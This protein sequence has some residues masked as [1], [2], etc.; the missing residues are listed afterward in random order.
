MKIEIPDNVKS[1]LVQYIVD[2]NVES[3]GEFDVNHMF[4]YANNCVNTIACMPDENFRSLMSAGD[5]KADVCKH[6]SRVPIKG[7]ITLMRN[8]KRGDTDDNF[9]GKKVC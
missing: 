6:L 8:P 9:G 2:V 1:Y 3:V 7:I 5:R 4:N